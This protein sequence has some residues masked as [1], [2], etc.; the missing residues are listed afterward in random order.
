MRSP[1]QFPGRRSGLWVPD[2]RRGSGRR[3]L[4]EEHASSRPSVRGRASTQI[5][6]QRRADAQPRVPPAATACATRS[7]AWGSANQPG[8]RRRRSPVRVRRLMSVSVSPHAISCLRL[9]TPAP[10]MSKLTP[11]P[12]GIPKHPLP[13]LAEPCGQLLQGPPAVKPKVP[14]RIGRQRDRSASGSCKPAVSS[15]SQRQEVVGQLKK[16]PIVPPTPSPF[17]VAITF[18]QGWTTT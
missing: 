10:L 6:Y 13:P 17:G 16:L 2:G 3:W 9:T 11:L 8:R 4:P 18:S 7:S 15:D 5:P 14:P 12:I 1:G